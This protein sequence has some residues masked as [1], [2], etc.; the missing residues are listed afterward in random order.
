MLGNIFDALLKFA[1]VAPRYIG[2]RCLV[3]K[4]VVDGCDKCMQVCPHD[5]IEISDKVK[6]LT[7]LC[8]GCGLCVQACP[9][10]ALEYDLTPPLLALK[11]QGIVKDATAPVVSQL[12]CS[13]VLTNSI[14]D[15]PAIDCMGHVTPALLMVSAAWGQELQLIHSDCQ[16]C[17]LGSA[18]VPRLLHQTIMAANAYRKKLAEPEVR[19][20]MVQHMPD[21]INISAKP[22]AAQTQQEQKPVSRREAFS[23]FFGQA[24]RGAV[25]MIPEQPIPGIDT[26]LPAER[27]PD[28]FT[29]RQK[30]L[31][32]TPEPTAL[33]YWPTPI[34]NDNCIMCPVCENVCPTQ[35]LKRHPAN[36][37]T[38]DAKLWLEINACVGCNACVVSC[39]PNAMTLIPEIEYKMFGQTTILFDFKE[40][41]YKE[42]VAKKAAA[43]ISDQE[44]KASE[45]AEQNASE[46]QSELHNTVTH[47][48]DVVSDNEIIE[49]NNIETND[50][51]D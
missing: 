22:I 9:T 44:I 15:A 3:E 40:E 37:G 13:K 29:W 8:T 26:S 24:K 2:S 31:K 39:P 7:D 33:Q 1:D 41:A 34:V 38:Y 14:P 32:P 12:R 6:V 5:A 10:A 21:G 30:S 25:H 23:A 47:S 36:D 46:A 16:N 35:A 43:E 45:K 50:K 48:E 18:S 51:I 4:Q 27:V 42:R 17:K 11:K 49:A 20:H 28:E 19:A